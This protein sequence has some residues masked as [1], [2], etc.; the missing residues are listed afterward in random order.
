MNADRQY[1]LNQVFEQAKKKILASPEDFTWNET[2]LALEISVCY[3]G[4]ERNEPTEQ[5]CRKMAKAIIKLKPAGLDLRTK[6]EDDGD[7]PESAEDPA[8]ET[9]PNGTPFLLPIA[10]MEGYSVDPYGVVHADKRFGRKAGPLV[11]DKFFQSKGKDK[12]RRFVCGY[13][14]RV[15]GKRRRYRPNYFMMARFFAEQKWMN[16]D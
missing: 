14:V 4:P 10:D 8:Q 2:E 15:G 3:S 6:S 1:L 5:E 16:G 12:A 13:R 7:S 9:A 11:P